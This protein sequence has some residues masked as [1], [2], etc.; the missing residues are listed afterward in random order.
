MFRWDSALEIRLFRVV[1]V[2][3]QVVFFHSRFL[4]VPHVTA[5]S[6]SAPTI[7]LRLIRY[8]KGIFVP[9]YTFVVD[10][11]IVDLRWQ[12]NDSPGF[13]VHA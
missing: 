4:A 1:C 7:T 6:D 11:M 3:F 9:V 13:G 10:D 2:L 8:I 12:S 5:G